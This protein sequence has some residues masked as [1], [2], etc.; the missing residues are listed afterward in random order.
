MLSCFFACGV[1][2]AGAHSLLSLCSLH[3]LLPLLHLVL[4]MQGQGESESFFSGVIEVRWL[5]TLWVSQVFF[6]IFQAPPHHA[7]LPLAH[8]FAFSSLSL[9]SKNLQAASSFGLL[10]FQHASGRS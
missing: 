8:Y 4:H 1:S 7:L 3:Y 5:C 9:C 6:W 10:R 2:V